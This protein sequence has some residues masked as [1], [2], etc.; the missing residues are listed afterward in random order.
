MRTSLLP[1]CVLLALLLAAPAAPAVAAGP[2]PAGAV[3][4]TDVAAAI[5]RAIAEAKKAMMS[6]PARALSLARGVLAAAARLPEGREKVVATATGRWLEGEALIFLD[7]TAEAAPA[8]DAALSG[9]MQAA[10]NTKLHGD[11]LRSRGFIASVTG[12]TLDALRDYQ[13]AHDVFH[14]AGEQRSNALTLQDI[15]LIYHDAGDY[16]RALQYSRQ[17]E[18]AYPSD[19]MLTLTLRNNQAEAYRKQGRHAM[20]A[21]VYRTALAQARRLGAMLLQARINVNLAESEAEAGRLGRAQAAVDE[22][23]RLSASGEG[24]R[25]RRFVHGAA[26]MVAIARGDFD[27]AEVSLAR[28]F[29]GVDLEKSDTLFRDYHHAAARVFE[30]RGDSALA[31]RHLK[32]YQ[33]L[34]NEAQQLTASA[35]AQLM[36]A[37]FDFTNQNLQ[38]AKLRQDQQ[39]RELEAER[40]RRRSQ[41]ILF[42]GL[43]VAG[44]A[45]FGVLLFGFLAVRRSRD[46]V[47]A[48]NNSLT[49]VNTELE[50]ALKAKTEFLATTSHE[51]RTPLNGILGM[52][53]VLL[54]DRGVAKEV[55]ER[56]EVVHGAGETM[57]ALVDDILD[58]AKMES[59]ELTV[60]REPCDLDR[61]L[62][63]AARLWS[64]Q[65]QAKGLELVLDQAD[66]PRRIVSDGGRLRQIVFNLMSNALKFT[67]QG[68]VTLFAGVE[69]RA[70]GAETLVL[71]VADTGIG[72]PPEKQAEIFE[73]FRQVDGGTTRQ[74]GGTGLGLAI[75]KQLAVALGGDIRVESATGHGASFTVTLPLE[76]AEVEAAAAEELENNPALGQARML[77]LERN[78]LN[79]GVMRL[80]LAAEAES[81]TVCDGVGEAVAAMEAGGITHVVADAA[82]AGAEGPEVLAGLRELVAAANRTGAH[83]T[84]LLAPAAAGITVAEGMLVGASQLVVKP[85]GAADLMTALRSLYGD[86]PETLVAPAL[87]DA[88]AA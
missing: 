70:D 9:A 47:T 52:T 38:I 44:A 73:A 19:P 68:R 54:A 67:A 28:I 2:E 65:A 72:I 45:V 69:G 61:I 84:L 12:R 23:M 41:N 85:I 36:A 11:A 49:E 81:V 58:V 31:L 13:R 64:G 76:R 1:P 75:C 83:S 27:H 46:Q 18:A 55:R 74:Y 30:R 6:D 51:I 26:A 71:R 43:L 14:R 25:W 42:S 17:A 32:A 56:I 40:D 5:D 22:A 57:K 39:A 10:P 86:D 88:R 78:P 62:H 33:R 77:L 59:G 21:D 50:K 29:A 53:Q 80:L 7:K 20:A 82:S 48:A 37:R 66:A 15:G 16:D 79:Q 63:D 35:A 8:I 34:E 4:R 87:L 24:A 3:K 60:A